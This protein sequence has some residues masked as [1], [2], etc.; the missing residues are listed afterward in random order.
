M[1]TEEI[2]IRPLKQKDR[3]TVAVMIRKLADKVGTN[4]LMNIIVAD[5][6]AKKTDAKTPQKS[7]TFTRIGVEIVK[8]LLDVLEEDVVAWFADLIGKTPEEFAEMPFDIEMNIIEQLTN[9]EDANSF[10]T[11]ALRVFNKMKKYAP[12]SLTKKPV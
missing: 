1:S 8:Q 5:T 4:G 3:K 6:D 2:K 7:D 11:R 9:S 12:E 10:F